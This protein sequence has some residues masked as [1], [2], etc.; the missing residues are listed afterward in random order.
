MR[1]GYRFFHKDEL[2]AIEKE[3]LQVILLE[4]RP[5]V[6][7]MDKKTLMFFFGKKKPCCPSMG[8]NAF[9]LLHKGVY[10][11]DFLWALL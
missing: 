9:N 4:R 8:K 2:Y 3:Y 1:K 10:L 6:T 5:L 11:Q 7:S